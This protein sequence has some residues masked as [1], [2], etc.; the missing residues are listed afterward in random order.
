MVNEN[1]L[2]QESAHAEEQDDDRDHAV[3]CHGG[4]PA[5]HIVCLLQVC[6]IDFDRVVFVGAHGILS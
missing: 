3:F 6:R 4:E 2:E 1:P 5:P